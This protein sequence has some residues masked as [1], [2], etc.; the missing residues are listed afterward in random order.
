MHLGC[1]ERRGNEPLRIFWVLYDRLSTSLIKSGVQFPEEVAYQKILSSL[2]LPQNQLG[3][4]LSTLE[5]KNICNS[6][7]YLKRLSLKILEP[8]FITPSEKVLSATVES[9]LPRRWRKKIEL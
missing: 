8:S 6:I 5:S 1:F 4:L 9:D 3:L 7:A 2:K